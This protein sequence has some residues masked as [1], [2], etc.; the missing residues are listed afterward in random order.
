[1]NHLRIQYADSEPLSDLWE[2]YVLYMDSSLSVMQRK[3]IAYLDLSLEY[4]VTTG[5]VRSASVL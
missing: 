1:M 3:F 4:A 2:I 5:N